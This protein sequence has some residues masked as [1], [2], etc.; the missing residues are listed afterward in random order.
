MSSVRTNTALAGLGAAAAWLTFVTDAVAAEAVVAGALVLLP[1]NAF[2]RRFPLGGGWRGRGVVF[3]A[4]V[5]VA[6]TVGLLDRLVGHAPASTVAAVVLLVSSLGLL[7]TAPRRAAR[8][9]ASAPPVTTA[10]LPVASVQAP[11]SPASSAPA[12]APVVPAVRR[13]S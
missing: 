5:L 1:G 6:T 10:V 9:L 12:A 8:P 2:G 7:R 3:A 4:G 13:A 11:S